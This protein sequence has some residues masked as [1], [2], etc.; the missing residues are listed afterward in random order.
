MFMTVLSHEVFLCF[1]T[2][3]QVTPSNPK[4]SAGL[5]LQRG[6]SWAVWPGGTHLSLGVWTKPDR[7]NKQYQEE[8]PRLVSWDP[9]QRRRS[10]KH[11]AGVAVV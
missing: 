3:Q 4:S 6:E 7:T 8:K 2:Q 5:R 1:V 10:H 9:E 11:W